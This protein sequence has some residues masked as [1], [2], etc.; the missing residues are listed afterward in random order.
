MEAAEQ[1][2]NFASFARLELQIKFGRI[3]ATFFEAVFNDR[4]EQRSL[5]VA[6]KNR[7]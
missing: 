7:W 4:A 6:E 5:V 3:V 2:F 1:C